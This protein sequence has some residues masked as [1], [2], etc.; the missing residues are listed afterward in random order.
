MNNKFTRNN[1]ISR[2][3]DNRLNED[4]KKQLESSGELDELKVVIDEIDT[5]QIPKLDVEAGLKDLNNRKKTVSNTQ[6]KSIHKNN[7]GWMKIAASIAILMTI[8]YLSWN[9]FMN[10]TTTITTL[11]AENKTVELPCGTIVKVD[12]LSKVSFKENDWEN[13]RTIFLDGQA[14]F[15]VTK[16]KPFTVVTDLGKID[17]LGTQFNVKVAPDTF[18]VSCYEG[19][20]NVEYG[21]K[22]QK[23]LTKGKS[24]IG[25]KNILVSNSHNSTTPD[26]IN[27]VSKFNK[28]TLSA[29]TKEL[30]KYYD[31][32]IELPKKYEHLEFTGTLTH[33]DLNT[34]LNTLFS[35]MEIKYRIDNNR[36]IV[37]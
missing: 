29:I 5:W 16:G 37:E 25:E 18:E 7:Y 19:K 20:V 27:N 4:E 3:L 22:D 10:Q 6:V 23:I 2:W 11:V 17:V 35:S 26:W 36:I 34:A 28:D 30:E 24:V 14:F 21:D 12:A 31:I 8:S 9:Y 15:D 33:K 13:K 32:K 1:L